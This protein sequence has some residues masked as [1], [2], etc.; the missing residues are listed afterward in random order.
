MRLAYEPGGFALGCR[1]FAAHE[2]IRGN[3]AHSNQDS[4]GS[5]SAAKS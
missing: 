5:K 3:V 2:F 1:H 4:H